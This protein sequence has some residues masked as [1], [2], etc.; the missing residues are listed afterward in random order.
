MSLEVFGMLSRKFTTLWGEMGA[1]ELLAFLE[2]FPLL[3]SSLS[4]AVAINCAFILLISSAHKE[5]RHFTLT[6]IVK[7]NVKRM[8]AQMEINVLC[9]I[10][11]FDK[12][13]NT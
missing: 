12:D 9:S 5:S 4:A 8:L 7:G 2:C 11:L 1:K 10:C 6:R 3:N 13:L